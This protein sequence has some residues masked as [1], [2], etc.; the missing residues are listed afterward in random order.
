[1][2]AVLRRWAIRLPIAAVVAALAFGG[3][4]EGITTATAH[5]DPYVG[6]NRNTDDPDPYVGKHRQGGKH[7]KPGAQKV[8]PWGAPTGDHAKDGR[9]VRAKNKVTGMILEVWVPYDTAMNDKEAKKIARCFVN[10]VARKFIESDDPTPSGSTLA[11][12]GAE[13]AAKCRADYLARKAEKGDDDGG[14]GGTPAK[15]APK[16]PKSPPKNPSVGKVVAKPVVPK[17]RSGRVSVLAPLA[18]AVAQDNAGR[19]ERKQA[20][21]YERALRDPKLRK[22]IIADYNRLKDNSPLDDLVRD[23]QNGGKGFNQNDTMA[24]GKKLVE[25]Q[26]GMDKAKKAADTSNADPSYRHA[27]KVCNGYDTCVRDVT[28][29]NRK[30]VAD[31]AKKAKKSN[32]DPVYQHARSVCGGYDTCVRDVTRKNRKNIADAEKKAKKSNAD[33][34]YLQARRECGGYDTCVKQRVK[35]LREQAA[36]PTTRGTPTGKPA[37]QP[38]KE[39]VDKEDKHYGKQATKK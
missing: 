38:K 15:P 36:K 18:E 29:K 26:K 22:E 27:R 35:K 6:K 21:L 3:L 24:I 5:A 37:K 25:A 8:W 39:R 20:E 10:C 16:G 1:M 11:K 30:K 28:D 34:A 23:F 14:T 7:R 13:C 9:Y 17:G 4:A 32:D 2:R 33:P 19:V 31:A 12:W